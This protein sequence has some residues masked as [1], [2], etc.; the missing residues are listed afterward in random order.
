VA[1][2]PTIEITRYM[3]EF[4][5]EIIKRAPHLPKE[6]PVFL[7]RGHRRRIRYL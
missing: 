2:L 4:A 1:S 5:G 6:R 3:A 7:T